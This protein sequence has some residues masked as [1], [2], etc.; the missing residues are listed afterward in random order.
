MLAIIGTA[1]PILVRIIGLFL[2]GSAQKQVSEDAFVKFVEA[3]SGDGLI[4][5]GLHDSY[6]AQQAANR[7]K[8]A[9]AQIPPTPKA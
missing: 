6:A 5:K 8:L 1:L 7:A 2:D 3:L 9:A 4:S